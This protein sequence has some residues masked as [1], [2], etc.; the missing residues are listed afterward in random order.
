M[1]GTGDTGVAEGTYKYGDGLVV[2]EANPIGEQIGIKYSRI[3]G[4]FDDTTRHC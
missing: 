3:L 4:Y 2:R 1:K